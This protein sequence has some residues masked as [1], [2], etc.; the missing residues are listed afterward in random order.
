MIEL[1]AYLPDLPDMNNPGATVA[2]NVLPS[3]KGY[4]PW[5]SQLA[6]SDA[7]TARCRGAF[8]AKDKDGNVYV[9][10][11]DA[12][13]LY[14]LSADAWSN[15]SQG[16][17]ADAYSLDDEETWEFVK[18]GEKIIA[19]SGVNT[20]T[21]I[22]DTN[23]IQ[24]ITMGGANFA[25]LSGSPPQARHIAVVRDFVVVGNT[26]DSSDGLVPNRVRW[27]GINDETTWAVSATTQADYQD[28]YGGGWVQRITG[29]EY[30]LVFMEGAIWRMSYVGSPIVWQFDEIL[31]GRGTPCPGSVAQIGDKVFFLSQEGFEVVV[32][33][34]SA[35]PIGAQRID[36]TFFND[37]DATYFHRVTATV[38]PYNRRV[39]WAY[40]GSGSVGGQPNKVL[41][42][43]W[44]ADRWSYSEQ[45]VQ[46]LFV[47]ATTGYTM[48]GLDSVDSNLDNIAETLDSRA[49]MGGA[50]QIGVFD[51]SNNL[52]LWTGSNM[53][54]V[55]ET[56]EAEIT[57]GQRSMIIGVRPL[58][59]GGATT[60]QVGCRDRQQDAYSWSSAASVNA[61]GIARMR[62]TARYHRLRLNVSGAFT[63]AHGVDVEAYPS[64]YR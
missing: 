34:S 56:A 54:G 5:P 20:D 22:A 27:C 40:P 30:G 8:Y 15:V 51:S 61:N 26:W 11:G 29:G 38:D 2:K 24:I 25:D 18:W 49:W 45:D 9:Y 13:K 33:G 43:D 42:Y 28:I 62:K 39:F 48:D 19:V 4:L 6:F 37:F 17:G 64:G 23:D 44:S 35:Q 46:A 50:A 14:A 36:R 60:V 41:C 58:V 53:S 57:P 63:H 31:P 21:A 59:D 32:N 7:L 16:G 12:T 1:G 52:A 47:A 10:A 55:V 3:A